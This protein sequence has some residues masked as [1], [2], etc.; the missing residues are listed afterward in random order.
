MWTPTTR[1]HY[2]REGLRYETDLTDAE[3]ALIEPLLPEPLGQGR[4]PAWSRREI[5]NAIFYV[6]RG[7]ISWRLLPTDLP[8]KSTVFRWFAVES[9]LCL[10]SL[11]AWEHEE[12]VF[13]I[14]ATRATCSPDRGLDRVGLEVA[15]ADLVGRTWHHLL[16]G[17]NTR[18][19]QA[20]DPVV[21]DAKPRGGIR[22][23][24]PVAI[25]VRGPVSANAVD[26]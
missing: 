20:A 6:L 12:L 3:W 4:P 18:L 16:S 21:R 22:H 10:P 2:S 8:P 7:G 13:E 17:E 11:S 14:G 19:N 1:R 25:L 9:S 23:G 15:G 24:E 26:A 5:M